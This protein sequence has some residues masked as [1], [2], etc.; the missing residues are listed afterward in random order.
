VKF[1]DRVTVCVP[2]IPERNQTLYK[3][4][5]RSLQM[6]TMMPAW[7]YSEVDWDGNGAA[8]TKNSLLSLVTTPWVAFMD[9]DDELL[10]RH[11]E[12]LWEGQRSSGA[13]VV[14]SWPDGSKGIDPA[15]DKFGQPFS[16]DMLLPNNLI[17]TTSLFRTATLKSTGGFQYAGNIYVDNARPYANRDGAWRYDD[18]GAYLA[19]WHAGATFHH[20]AERTWI[21]RRHAGQTGGLR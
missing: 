21:Y 8:E 1:L 15:P 19:L 7:F 9:D 6:Q 4:A 11:L 16:V 14:Y 17:P 13:D 5:L 10:P 2:R 20:V 18:W 3:A 12:A